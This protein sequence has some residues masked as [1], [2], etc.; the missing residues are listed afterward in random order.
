MATTLWA[1]S[2]QTVLELKKKNTVICLQ[3]LL[4]NFLVLYAINVQTY[5][6]FLHFG[7]Y[8]QH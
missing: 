8:E 5:T 3:R 7:T 1:F 2:M 4:F 6:Y